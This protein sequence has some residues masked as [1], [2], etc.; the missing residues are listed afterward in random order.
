MSKQKIILIAVA[1]LVL[2]FFL[3]SYL[4]KDAQAQKAS[5]IAKKSEEV[6]IRD[7]STIVGKKDAKVTL[8][9]FLDPACGACRAF[10]PLIKKIMEEHPDQIKH[11]IRYAPF[12]Q[13]S[14]EVVKIIEASKLQDK[15]FE[16]LELLFRY[17]NKWTINHKV[18]IKMVWKILPG[19]GLD[20]EKLQNDIKNPKFDKLI[21]QEIADAK[22]L[23]VKKTPGYFVNGKPL[24]KFGYE[25]LKELIESQL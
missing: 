4:Y 21:E 25:Q 9:E 24:Q 22:K 3:G 20:I 1:V 19:I 5:A 17:Q 2:I 11:V 13:G 23:G 7:Y 15:Y 16:T 6:F 12:H 8:V 18:D 10:Y 14:T